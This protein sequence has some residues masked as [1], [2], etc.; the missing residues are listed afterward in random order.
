[1][2]PIKRRI[3]IY[4][5]FTLLHVVSFIPHDLTTFPIH[6]QIAEISL[7]KPGSLFAHSPFPTPLWRVDLPAY[8]ASG[9]YIAKSPEAQIPMPTPSPGPYLLLSTVRIHTNSSKA[10]CGPPHLPHAHSNPL[11]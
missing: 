11:Q 2:T 4:L 9:S 8:P 7:R 5:F 10:N 6:G 3:T 1:M